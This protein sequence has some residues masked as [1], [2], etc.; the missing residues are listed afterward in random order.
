ML[1]VTEQDSGVQVLSCQSFSSSTSL[2]CSSLKLLQ[3]SKQLSLPALSAE[4]PGCWDCPASQAWSIL[5]PEKESTAL[6]IPGVS[7]FSFFLMSYG[8]PKSHPPSIT[9]FVLQK[10]VKFHPAENLLWFFFYLLVL[11]FHFEHL[12]ILFTFWKYNSVTLKI[13]DLCLYIHMEGLCSVSLAFLFLSFSL[14]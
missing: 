3:Y 6:E 4:A 9:I 2:K 7:S 11:Q 5:P 14:R 13:Y 10:L 12:P 1:A 8:L